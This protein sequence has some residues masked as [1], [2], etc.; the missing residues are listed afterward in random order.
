MKK[1]KAVP[2]TL[3]ASIAAIVVAGC[4][5]STQVRRCVDNQGNLL[6]D[7]Q[8]NNTTTHRTGGFYPHWVYGGA[9]SGR[10]VTGYSNTPSSSHDIVNSNGSVVRRGFGGGSSS[11]SSFGS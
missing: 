5:N 7:S 11:H 9:L 6:P 2:A 1:S 4:G 10:R 8:C 3:V